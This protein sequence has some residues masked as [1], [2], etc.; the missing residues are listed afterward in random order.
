MGYM[1]TEG[2]DP[3]LLDDRVLEDALDVGVGHRLL[4]A[5]RQLLLAGIPAADLRACMPQKGPRSG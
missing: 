3:R 2:R 4:T 1:S 5:C